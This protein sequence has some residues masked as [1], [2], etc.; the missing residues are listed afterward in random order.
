MRHCQLAAAAIILLLGS[1]CAWAAS[2]GS[3]QSVVIEGPVAVPLL[4]VEARSLPE[5]PDDTAFIREINRRGNPNA[6]EPD[7]GRRGTWDRTN[8]P[9]D[10][11]I[12]AAPPAPSTT[13]PATVNVEGI[14]N[15]G[16]HPPDVVGTVGPSHY[17][18]M[19][20]A[21]TVRVLDKAGATLGSF[22]LGNLWPVG[23]TCRNNNGDPIPAYDQFADRW[24]LSQFRS[25]SPNRMCV[26]IS[27][28]RD[29]LG[30]YFIYTFD[31]P[32]F[33][34]YFKF[35]VWPDA[36]YMSSN[37]SAYAA[38]AFDRVRM[39]AGQP[40]TFQRFTGQSNLLLP[41]DIDGPTL[42]PAGTPGLF[43][44]YKDNSF[45]GGG[46]VD[47]IE[48]F[49]FN[50]DWATPANSSFTLIHSLPVAQFTYTVC[51]AFNF[52]CVRQLGTTQRLDTISE[53]PMFRFAY[54]NF[55]AHQS[56]VGSYTIG[57]GSGEEGGAIRWFELRNSGSGWSLFQEGT[58]DP[59]DGHDRWNSSIAMDQDGNMALGYS[60]GS[61]TIRPRIAYTTRLASDPPGS[62]AAEELLFQGTGVHTSNNR[63]GDYSAMT[64]DPLDDCTFWYT[65][66]YMSGGSTAF[67][68]R[69]GAFK[70]PS[71]GAPAGDDVFAD[72]FE[73]VVDGLFADGFE[74]GGRGHGAGGTGE[75]G[76]E[77]SGD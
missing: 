35:G 60:V 22:T 17:V 58:F 33:P 39:L 26:A 31:V 5:P 11:L 54:R 65:N 57:G 77:R 38:Y 37:E 50:V 25:A 48:L 14:S 18:Q 34:D 47:R 40:A 29:P 7:Q 10:P 74:S 6:G 27:Q 61:S 73:G 71:C 19:V 66:E 43:Y 4:S 20:N 2:S 69:I 76:S 16:V 45:H 51:G 67:R 44:T 63:W 53:W 41:A 75:A 8:V 15:S 1:R 23:Q 72:G 3:N 12:G 9:I 68:T 36:Y 32:Q 70:I 42:P 30:A 28:T 59:G 55:G 21:T 64:V 13:P 24:L 46:G 49:S 52:N 56:A 62:M